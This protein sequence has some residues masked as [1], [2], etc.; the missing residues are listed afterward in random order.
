VGQYYYDPTLGDYRYNISVYAAALDGSTFGNGTNMKM[1]FRFYINATSED[2]PAV[3]SQLIPRYYPDVPAEGGYA[4]DDVRIDLGAAVEQSIIVYP[5]WNFISFYVYP[6]STKIEE[7]FNSIL[8]GSNN[9]LE[10]AA[11]HEKYWYG[12]TGGGSL[13]DVDAYNSYYLKISASCP[14]SGCALNIIG[15]RLDPTTEFTLTR[16]WQNISYLLDTGNYAIKEGPPDYAFT[17]VFA[18]I[19]DSIAWLKGATDENGQSWCSPEVGHLRLGPGR[20]LFIKML[21]SLPDDPADPNAVKFRY[22][23]PQQ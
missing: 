20:G 23:E 12:A 16:G 19:K 15:L 17:G 3:D 14:A 13:T 1:N 4:G 8:T 2:I 11:S 6:E 21:D 7:A 18:G 5:G 22:A 10:Y 9:Y